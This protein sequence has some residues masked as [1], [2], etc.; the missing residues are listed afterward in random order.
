MPKKRAKT[1]AVR[2]PPKSRRLVLERAQAARRRRVRR[3]ELARRR[4]SLAAKRGWETRRRRAR[5]ADRR[6]R[7]L[8]KKRRQEQEQRRRKRRAPEKKPAKPPLEETERREPRERKRPERP[9][10]ERTEAEIALDYFKLVLH[11][12]CGRLRDESVVCTVRTH[13]EGDGSV[14]AEILIPVYARAPADVRRLLITVEELDGWTGIPKA[15][16]Q[17]CWVSI[18]FRVDAGSIKEGDDPKYKVSPHRGTYNAPT[19]YHRLENA[20][21]AFQI[22]RDAI[23][24]GLCEMSRVVVAIIM[25]VRYMPDGE[26][27]SRPR[28]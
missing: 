20:A 11:S 24:P 28:I 26:H 16:L 8:A 4:R 13:R 3:K 27:P 19:N 23:L 6:R 15:L 17:K 5:T 18:I 22:A 7:E 1:R 21:Y 25:R 10:K 9:R 14:S 12:T 2:R